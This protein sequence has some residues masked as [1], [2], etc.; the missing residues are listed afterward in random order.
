METLVIVEIFNLY[1]SFRSKG[2]KADIY[3][4]DFD[5]KWVLP[6]SDPDPTFEKKPVPNPTSEKKLDPDPTLEKTR[7]L[8]NFT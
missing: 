1:S 7:I 6:G 4:K 8:P 2:F 3:K 5:Y